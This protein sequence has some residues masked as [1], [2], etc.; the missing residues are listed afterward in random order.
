MRLLPIA[1]LV[2]PLL[3][4][5]TVA[6]S[7]T[8]AGDYVVLSIP[9]LG[10]TAGTNVV[11]GLDV[12]KGGIGWDLNTGANG[13]GFAMVSGGSYPI[14]GTSSFTFSSLDFS[15]GSSLIGFENL[16]SV[17]ANTVVTFTSRSITFTFTD[18]PITE[19]TLISGT[20]V[21]DAPI[22]PPSTT[23]PLPASVPLMASAFGALAFAARR[24]NR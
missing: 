3:A 24:R 13:N 22:L 16:V 23:V 8:L 11:S 19:G 21:T 9:T 1:S 18:G 6:T 10:V 4:S 17:F 7:S 2:F 14:V 12:A 5:A 15:D 20:F